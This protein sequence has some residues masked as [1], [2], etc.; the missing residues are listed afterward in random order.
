MPKRLKK[1]SADPNVAARNVVATITGDDEPI[2]SSA[3]SRYMS[4]LGRKG[5]LASGAKRMSNLSS[6]TRSEIALRAATARWDK[7]RAKK[8]AAK[9]R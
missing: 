1:P 3:L 5:G 8:K 2:P 9:K 7:E 4:Q 6:T